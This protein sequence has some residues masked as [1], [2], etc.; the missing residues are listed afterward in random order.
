[1]WTLSDKQTFERSITETFPKGDMLA[2]AVMEKFLAELPLQHYGSPT[3]LESVWRH[4][5]M[6]IRYRL[7][8]TTQQVEVLSVAIAESGEEE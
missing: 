3:C 4:G 2:K 6:A 5:K 1:M 7:R 8:S